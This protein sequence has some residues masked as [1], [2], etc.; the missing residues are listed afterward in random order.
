M[1][2]LRADLEWVKDRTIRFY[3][4]EEWLERAIAAEAELAKLREKH[5]GEGL[6]VVRENARLQAQV[7]QLRVQL[8]GCLTAAEG[9][10]KEHAKEDKQ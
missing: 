9:W 1:R 8:A 3:E 7:E 6:S 5:Y 4:Q 2:D 10:D